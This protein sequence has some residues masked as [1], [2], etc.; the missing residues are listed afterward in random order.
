VGDPAYDLGAAALA[1]H[2]LMQGDEDL[3]ACVDEL[4]GLEAER[5]ERLHVRVK[6]LPDPF[7]TVTGLPVGGAFAVA[8]LKIARRKSLQN[9]LDTT[10]IERL[11]GATE[12]LH[13]PLEHL[14]VP[15]GVVPELAEVERHAGLIANDLCIVARWNREHVARTGLSLR[16]V[17]HVDLHASGHDVAEVRD[18]A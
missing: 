10:F 11:V 14:L 8:D 16:A 4:F 2:P 13:V 3:V 9:G 12:P 5:G 1:P 15:L 6:Q 7:L 18:L 17:V